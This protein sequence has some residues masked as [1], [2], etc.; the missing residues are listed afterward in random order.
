MNKINHVKWPRNAFILQT[1]F[2]F[3]RESPPMVGPSEQS[4]DS[5]VLLGRVFGVSEL[6]AV[7]FKSAGHRARFLNIETRVSTRL[8]VQRGNKSSFESASFRQKMQ[9]AIPAIITFA[10]YEY[11]E[12]RPPQS[13]FSGINKTTPT[14]IHFNACQRFRFAGLGS[15]A[16]SASST[17]W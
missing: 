14:D 6:V 12:R 5:H 2:P 17:I 1:G 9:V 13:K 3:F 4:G 7:R 8:S 15:I 16:P 11:A 10:E